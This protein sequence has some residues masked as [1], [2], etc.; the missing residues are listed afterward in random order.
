MARSFKRLKQVLSLEEKQG[1]QNK[2]VVG[3]IRQFANFWVSQAREEA[4]D[5]ADRAL[6]EQIAEMLVDYGRLP[7]REAR[8]KAIDSLMTHLQR[9][10]ER[11]GP[12]AAPKSNKK[13]LPAQQPKPKPAQAQPPLMA[14]VLM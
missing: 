4:V 13:R 5:E 9:R 11:L 8:S 10:E 3:G 1:Y 7:G 2:A 6:V 12:L 14:R